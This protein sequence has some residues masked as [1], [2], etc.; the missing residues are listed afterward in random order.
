MWHGGG[1]LEHAGTSQQRVFWGMNQALTKLGY[2]AVF[3][4]LGER[5]ESEQENAARE[6]QHLRYVRDQGFGGALFYPYAYRHNRDLVQEV[7]QSVPL[8]L[9]DRRISGTDVD[10]VGIENY[11]TS[12]ELTEHLIA[13]GHRRIAHVTSSQ[14]IQSVQDR[15]QGY[16]DAM[17][18]A[19]MDAAPDMGEM[20]LH[21]PN[22]ND[23]RA[24]TAV[25][26]VFSLPK[27]LRPTA[28]VCFTDYMAVALATRLEHLGLSIPGDIALTGFDNIVPTLSNGIGLTTAAQPYEE[29]GISAVDLLMR[30][31]ADPRVSTRSL[32]LPVPLVIRASSVT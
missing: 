7:S 18:A 25:D 10:F 2:H 15:I 31:I 24:W 17:R 13:Q 30:R 22:Y 4:D 5:I 28:A 9:L 6:A 26:A 20:L 29:I 32:E 27:V 8:V 12:R 23:D 1:P 19:N 16:L 11:G 3:L 21:V 14:P